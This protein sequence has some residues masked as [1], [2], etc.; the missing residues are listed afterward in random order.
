[1]KI[2]LKKISKN[3]KSLMLA[4]DQGLE[5]GPSD[6]DD[7]N[8]DPAY[9]LEIAKKG[10]YNAVI[11]QKGIAE[12]Y[13]DGK[14]PLVLKLNGKTKLLAGEPY[15]PQICSVK[16][17]VDIGADAVGYTI[18]VGSKH[19]A[20]IFAEFSKIEEEAHKKGIPVICWMYPR[21]E[22]IK[23]EFDREIL[24]YSARVG[25]ELGADILKMKYNGNINDLKWVVKNAGKTKVMIAGGS[26]KDEK[27]LLQECYDI[28]NAGCIGMAIGRNVW[29]HK[30]PIGM[31]KALKSIIFDRKNVEQAMK[32]IG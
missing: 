10:K 6:F 8:V 29:Q 1:M 25:L 9:I 15:S 21:G 17:A 32:L 11:L 22:A 16:E 7:K 13:Y 5:H 14:V 28:V 3:G 23:N 30:N 12:K 20:K 2:N 18:Y 19:E 4:Y 27:Q 26:K 31:T 24:A